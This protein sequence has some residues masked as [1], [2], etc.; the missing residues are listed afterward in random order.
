MQYSFF[1][2]SANGGRVCWN[3]PIKVWLNVPKIVTPL[4]NS[5]RLFEKSFDVWLAEIDEPILKGRSLKKDQ[6]LK[7]THI[8]SKWFSCNLRNTILRTSN[9]QFEACQR[10]ITFCWPI[11]PF[12]VHSFEKYYTVSRKTHPS[13]CHE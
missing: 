8:F 3:I 13:W 11:C 9:Q 1:Y 5:F 4:W 10:I 6:E 2:D 12:N 7:Y